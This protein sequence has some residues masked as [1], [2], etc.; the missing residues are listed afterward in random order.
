MRKH[1]NTLQQLAESGHR[2]LIQPQLHSY[3]LKWKQ[4]RFGS[5]SL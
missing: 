4:T 2:E 3:F 1:A 5:Q